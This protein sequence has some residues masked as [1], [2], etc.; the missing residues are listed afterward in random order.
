MKQ[1][2]ILFLSTIF[3]VAGMLFSE[4]VVTKRV[5]FQKEGYHPKN[6]N[7]LAPDAITCPDP[8]VLPVDSTCK[9]E[10]IVHT[11]TSSCGNILSMSY[12]LPDGT[13][14]NVPPP[15]PSTINLGIWDAGLYEVD[16]T[17]TDEC[18]GINTMATC[19]QPIKLD[20]LPPV[21]DCPDD[22]SVGID[23]N[24]RRYKQGSRTMFVH[25]D[26]PQPTATDNCTDGQD[27][28]IT[29][30]S[31]YSSDPHDASGD[32]PLGIT[33]VCWTAT[34][35]SGNTDPCCMNIIVY[36]N[37]PPMITCPDTIKADCIAPAPY[38][39]F[40]A[41][42]DAGGTADDEIAL[43][44]DSFTFVQDSV[45]SETC[46][47]NL[48][49]HR[50]Y[51]IA[52]T[53]GNRDTCFQ[54]IVINDTIP[55]MAICKDITV[56]LDASGMATLTPQMLDDGSTDNCGGALTFTTDINLFF[57]CNDVVAGGSVVVHLIVTDACG[58]S[59]SC[60]S[61]VTVQ[62]VT[63][64]SITCPSNITVNNDVGV[65]YAT[66]IN[67]GSP[68]FTDN[69]LAWSA[70]E[71]TFNGM[72][73]TSSTQIPLG[74]N[75]IVWIVTDAGGN[76]ASCAQLVTVEDHEA[77]T[78]NCPIDITVNTNSRLCY[79]DNVALGNPLVDDNCAVDGF[80]ATFSGVPFTATTQLPTG[81]NAVV[82][83][84]TDESGNTSSCVQT[85]T[86]IDT[87]LPLI[88]CPTGLTVDNDLGECF[89]TGINPG[90]PL[91]SDNCG[92][93]AEAATFNGIPFDTDTQIPVGT[94]ILIWTVTDIHGN[95][96][97]CAQ[98]I[99]VE[100]HEA[101][102]IICPPDQDTP[103]EDGCVII[104]PD[105]T[106]QANP[107]DNCGV[108]SVIQNPVAG[109]EIP[110][111]L[112][113]EHTVTFIVTDNAGNT[114]SCSMTL[115][116]KD[117][118]GPQ[119]TCT[120]FRVTAIED[121]PIL[122][123]ASFIIEAADE[124]GGPLTYE[125]RRMGNICGSNTPST[126]GPTVEFCCDDV[127]DTIQ[128]IVRVY[129]ENGNFSECMSSVLV[130]DNLDPSISI[131]LPDVTISCEYEINLNDLDA[132]GT[133]VQSG[134]TRG[135]ILIDDPNSYY[136]PTGY[137]GQDGVYEDNCQDVIVTYTVRDLR[138][139]CRTG[140]IKRDFVLTDKGG[141]TATYTQT[142]I[143]QDADPF[144]ESDIGW[145]APEVVIQGCALEIPSP[146]S[147]GRP[148]V[149]D[150]NCSMAG[151]SFKD[152][153]YPHPLYCY[154]IERTWKVRDWC[155]ANNND[156]TGP[157][158]WTF[159]QNI[160]IENNVPPVIDSVVCTNKI[161]CTG[162]GCV[163]KN[164]SFTATGTDDCQ[165]TN[166]TWSYKI[167]LDN[168]G[169]IDYTGN[170]ATTTPRDYAAGTHKLIWQAK[171]GCGN[172]STCSSLFTVK[173]CKAPTG[174]VLNGLATNLMYPSGMAM[175]KASDFNNFSFD[176]CT[177]ANQLR[178]SFSSNVNDTLRIFNCDSL[179]TRR[180]EF[181][182]T[183]LEG[184]QT[185]V[186]TFL[187][188][189][190]NDN[191]CLGNGQIAI[192][193]SIYTEDKAMI[194]DAMVEIQGGE[195]DRVNYTD[196]EGHFNFSDL[197]MYNDYIL[198][199]FKK[200]SWT[201]G[202]ST[203][204]LVVIQRHILDIERLKSPYSII[205]ADVNRSNS[206]TAS[207]ISD[208]RKLILGIQDSLS[209]N[210]SWRFIDATSEFEDPSRPWNVIE[211]I[212]YENLD[213]NMSQT[214]FIAIKIGDVNG[215]VSS[216]LLGKAENRS[217][218]RVKMFADR[219]WIN[220]NELTEIPVA[221][222]QSAE[223]SGMQFTLQLPQ[224]V[225]YKGIQPE[226]LPI[227]VENT[228]RT[229]RNGKTYLNV[230]FNQA[231]GIILEEGAILFKVI[232]SSAKDINSADVLSLYP[233]ML[234]PEVYDAA[235]RTSSLQLGYKTPSWDVK[236]YVS[237]NKPNPFKENTTIEVFLNN[238][239]EVSL[240]IFD[241]KGSMVYSG[242]LNL[243]AGENQL[244]IGQQQLG[245]RKGIFYCKIKSGE[246]NEVVKMLRIE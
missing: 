65:C 168:N 101:P 155:Q 145:P 63:P 14:V 36:D 130:Q 195:T 186:V 93:M 102:S 96:A 232:V 192:S 73:I 191:A 100:D 188:V 123:A 197:G 159:V 224:G 215:T 228:Y 62:D 33:V 148:Q 173:D 10:V 20:T 223:I 54:V 179:G 8:V 181:F 238:R 58:N 128:V 170:G 225:E 194:S 158:I 41:F 153:V 127:S 114:A 184:N 172:T 46:P 133:F 141:N 205:A 167:D 160:Y 22:V 82:W 4:S 83:V 187:E 175:M 136:P 52:D 97:T 213:V 34:D 28:D 142:I 92:V 31:P 180:I 189:Q 107:S 66:N 169:S 32:Y 196:N 193:G 236:S 150:H 117:L 72:P 119:I 176:N 77:P 7:L 183:D 110:S 162:N 111:G 216:N 81:D 139:M 163:G 13:V 51:S 237:Q 229:E 87:E 221:I 26:V 161:I 152:R 132:F 104:V 226:G 202:I 69:C 134:S 17:V 57:G 157:G 207:D 70:A 246:L 30:D 125:V 50:Y 108:Q 12:T 94:N 151:V 116:A 120:D 190:D 231:D 234:R 203:L 71:P 240:S 177:P 124:C 200:G 206:I 135:D 88:T 129:D 138:S 2:S 208:L 15:F 47:N 218:D 98:T 67:Y 68:V 16:W 118:N 60:S 5:D 222:G 131:P 198:T 227:R 112:D 89:A 21:I 86:V 217:A 230:S 149:N 95:T 45:I 201:E 214:D 38:A 23:E 233:S 64:P 241:A 121:H 204:D 35:D 3:V 79:A 25:V 242:S 166:I 49:I 42:E 156:D 174:V 244:Q 11:P 147:T 80:V 115:T 91:T 235:L 109:T 24:G 44:E 122:T 27:I 103:L 6:V 43:D 99:T 143:V 211:H 219:K 29:H 144:D 113:Q 61:M 19:T 56:N 39:D 18:N 178:F 90:T 40:D 106:S 48:L 154:S 84:V 165:P 9:A 182:V 209:K 245:D 171:D 137:V 59:S 55:P 126:F 239:A 199:P 37:V 53:T 212:L 164:V 75:T 140:E 78:I 76:T 85:V 243:G 1:K 185:K 146:D 74:T 220:K 210:T 105:L